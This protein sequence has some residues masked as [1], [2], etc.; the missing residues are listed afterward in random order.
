[1]GAERTSQVLSNEEDEVSGKPPYNEGINDAF[2]LLPYEQRAIVTLIALTALPSQ[3][4]RAVLF[5]LC[6][7]DTRE[8]ARLMSVGESAV[9]VYLC[10]AKKRI[11]QILISSQ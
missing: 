8:V 2:Q 3:E 1:M 11:R 5:T 9:R 7:L 10:R 4:T 6:D